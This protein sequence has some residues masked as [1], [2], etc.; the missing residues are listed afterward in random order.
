[1]GVLDLLGGSVCPG[2]LTG[3]FPLL[4]GVVLTWGA[5]LV[6]YSI[7]LGREELPGE[8]TD[9]A[10]YGVAVRSETPLGSRLVVADLAR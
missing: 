3:G 8:F 1:M 6:S 10:A 5:A 9:A 2:N 4:A 7:V